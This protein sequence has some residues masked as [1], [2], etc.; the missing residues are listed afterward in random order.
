M[1]TAAHDDSDV[2][3]NPVWSSLTGAHAPMARI[4]GEARIYDPGVSVFAGLPSEPTPEAWADLAELLR[5]D[6]SGAVVVGTSV[7][8]PASWE[9]VRVIEG[10]QFVEAGVEGA[11][12]DDVVTLGD[13]DA[14]E[15]LALA[16]RTRPGPFLRGTVALGGYVGIRDRGSLVAMAGRRM[17]PDGWI[18]VSAV[19]TDEEYRGRGLGALLVRAI[20]DG[21]HRDGKR[22]FLHVEKGNDGAIGLYRKL[23]FEPSREMTF[24]FARPMPPDA[25]IGGVRSD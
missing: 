19:C 15:M 6:N 20:V 22:A 10:I 17:R 13:V 9:A 3:A 18:E 24:V 14:D 4:H 11:S 21:V 25:A 23:G 12:S 2:L 5:P 7:E 8:L 1:I 16:E